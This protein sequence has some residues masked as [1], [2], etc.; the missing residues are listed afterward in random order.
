MSSR[1]KFLSDFAF[2]D[3]MKA[4]LNSEI[5]ASLNNDDVEDIEF[6]EEKI[7]VINAESAL[8][9]VTDIPSEETTI[10]PIENN[11]VVADTKFTNSELKNMGLGET[12]L[13]I[14]TNYISRTA[15]PANI[16]QTNIIPGTT[17]FP[18]I[19]GIQKGKKIISAYKAI[20]LYMVSM[21]GKTKEHW[22]F[23]YLLTNGTKKTVL[24][25]TSDSEGKYIKLTEALKYVFKNIVEN[26][27]I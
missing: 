22:Y 13:D 8:E 26:N 16:M 24:V 4:T 10:A 7:S 2:S 9:H 20:G 11:L 17:V 5:P 27:N 3:S 12:V 15:G 14:L 6:T 1:I 25:K 19:K 23:H 21:V 18:V